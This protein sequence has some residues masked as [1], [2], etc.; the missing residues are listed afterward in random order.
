MIYETQTDVE[1]FFNGNNLNCTS[2]DLKF[3]NYT[4]PCE[5]APDSTPK[6]AKFPYFATLSL[7]QPAKNISNVSCQVLMKIV[8]LFEICK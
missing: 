1:A 6:E 8:S 3:E 4:L 7:K 2:K 5:M